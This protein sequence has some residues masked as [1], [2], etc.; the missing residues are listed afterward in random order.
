MRSSPVPRI[1]FFYFFLFR[2]IVTRENP[3]RRKLEQLIPIYTIFFFFFY[4]GL[5]TYSYKTDR[6]YSIK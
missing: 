2:D 4:V 6:S 1:L 3:S 5:K